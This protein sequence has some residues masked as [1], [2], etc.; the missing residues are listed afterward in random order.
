MYP[1]GNEVISV[2]FLYISFMEEGRPTKYKEGYN[3]QAY[4]LCLLGATDAELAGFFEV[5]E[6]TLHLW[7]LEH[8]EFSES[9]K[10]GKMVA[11]SNVAAALYK[12]ATGYRYLEVHKQRLESVSLESQVGNNVPNTDDTIL[13][14]LIEKEVS[15]DPGAALNW[16]KNRQPKKWR[17]KVE[18][19]N[20]NLN[21][22]S[23][24]LSQEEIAKISA[25]LESEY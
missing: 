1:K 17:D 6:S 18:V 11:D 14:K 24:D 13:T 9:V 2:G 15:P 5:A 7:K 25:Q 3:E 21:Y 20:T 22:S 23:S 8:F 16:L 10:R 19:T 12:R 4:K